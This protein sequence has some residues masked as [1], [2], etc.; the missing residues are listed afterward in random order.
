M[1]NICTTNSLVKRY[2]HFTALD[3]L[4]I[5][6]P[7]GAIYGL[8]GRNGAG[9][10]TLLRILSG[11]QRPTSGTFSLYGAESGTPEIRK[12]QQRMGAV[13]E[14]PSIYLGFTAEEN[15]KQQCRVLGLPSFQNVPELLSLV[16]LSRTG[17]RKARHFSLGMR[18]RLGIAVALVGD[19]DFLLLDEPANGLDPEGIVELRELILKLNRERD[20]TV[21]ISSHI[22]DELARL[23]T[24]YGFLDHGR[25]VQEVSA[26][27]LE[28]A[29]RKCMRV[30]VSET[31]PLA[32]ALGEKG[33]PHKI[34]SSRDAD[35]YGEISVSELAE[36]VK[37][38]GCTLLTVQEHNETLEG[39][40]MRLV[41]GS[42]NA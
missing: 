41:G 20:I 19:P 31:A 11:L 16:G 2:G 39:F 29:C 15:L 9:K 40:F 26:E 34:H 37:A 23:A 24:H 10:T 42:D 35:I 8:V 6:V 36:I 32:A 18:Q 25:A 38:A 28:A 1:E 3:R 21:L 7:R 12:A 33:I 17:K 13:I 30:T 14:T 4:S 27:E 22:L 5:S